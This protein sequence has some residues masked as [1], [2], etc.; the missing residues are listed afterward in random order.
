MLYMTK[1]APP[2]LLSK[3]LTANHARQPPPMTS[4]LTRRWFSQRS[5]SLLEGAEGSSLSIMSAKRL[6]RY[7]E[8][9]NGNVPSVQSGLKRENNSDPPNERVPAKKK[10]GNLDATTDIMA[11]STMQAM[12][13]LSLFLIHVHINRRKKGL[14]CT[15]FLSGFQTCQQE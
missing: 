6:L 14:R 4:I 1:Y 3:R 8:I 10:M 9:K 2:K 15:A 11:C 5:S 13:N 12:A 7:R